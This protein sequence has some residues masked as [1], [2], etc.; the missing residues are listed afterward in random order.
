M[1]SSGKHLKCSLDA[2]LK[3]NSNTLYFEWQE[4][5]RY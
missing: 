5:R 2:G 3:E 1:K 4:T